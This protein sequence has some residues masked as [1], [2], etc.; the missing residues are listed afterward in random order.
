MNTCLQIKLIF[1]YSTYVDFNS[2]YLTNQYTVK[3]TML[4][5]VYHYDSLDINR[6]I[7]WIP[8]I[9]FS[10]IT[11]NLNEIRSNLFN[12]FFIMIND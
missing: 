11:F 2:V 4:L 3:I 12:E 9:N 5:T 10:L 8:L 6:R 1:Y 7:N